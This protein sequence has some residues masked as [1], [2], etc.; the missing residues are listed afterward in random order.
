MAGGRARW[1][2]TCSLDVLAAFWRGRHVCGR[3]WIGGRCGWAF[4]MH[5]PLQS[6]EAGSRTLLRPATRGVGGSGVYLKKSR[7]IARAH[8]RHAL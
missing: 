8:P 4:E 7:G 6:G 2:A 3:A 1:V 5:V